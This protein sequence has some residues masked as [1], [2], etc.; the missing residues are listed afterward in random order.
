M[1]TFKSI[2]ESK[3]QVSPSYP[4][5]NKPIL[6]NLNHNIYKTTQMVDEFLDENAD[7]ANHSRHPT[8]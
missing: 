8:A 6:L 4:H 1:D 2:K 5:E 3:H 7:Y